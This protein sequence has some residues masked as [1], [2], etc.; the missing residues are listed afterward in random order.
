MKKIE[1]RELG[2]ADLE[3]VRSLCESLMKFQAEKAKFRQ[4]VLANMNFENRFLPDYGAALRKKVIAA[5]DGDICAGF[6]FATITDVTELNI[7]ARPTWASELGGN[8]FYPED[9]LVPKRIGTFKLL[10]VNSSYRGLDIGKHLSERSMN[11][12]K[13]SNDV[14]DL[15]VFVA[16]GNE[17]VGKFYKK[18]GFT[19]SHSVFNGF[20]D[21]YHQKR[22]N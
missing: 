3:T 14:E 19:F 13:S 2:S 9:Y 15:W 12:L 11:W 10:F 4:D 1:Y 17:E 18:Y 6:S 7:K 16:N 21:A 20:I 8:G 22:I 5:Y